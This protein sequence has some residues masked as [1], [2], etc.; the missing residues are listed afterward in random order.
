MKAFVVRIVFPFLLIAVGLYV[1]LWF[2]A[3]RSIPEQLIGTRADPATFMSS[4]ELMLAQEYSKLRNYFYFLAYPLEWFILLLLLFF[5]FG[6]RF[7]RW[8][9]SIT[10]VR[11][12][13]AGV[14]VFWLSFW[15]TLASLPLKLVRYYFSKQYQITVQPLS[16]W[17]RDQLVGFWEGLLLLWIVV[18]VIY[19]LMNKFKKYWWL[20][21]W[22]LF[23]PFIFFFM[24]V[25]PIII[26]PLYNDFYPMQNKEL[27]SKILAL[28]EEVD[29]PADRVWEVNMSEKTNAINAY[30]TGVGSNSRIVLWDTLLNRL[31]EEEILFVMAHELG[32]FVL[33]HVTLGITGYI[34]FSL[35][36]F[37]II[38][39]LCN[40]IIGRWGSALHI[41]GINQFAS[42]PL[43]L[44]L[45]SLLLFAT[46]PI[47]NYVSRHQEH[48]AD[49]FAIELT[50]NPDA[51]I[52]AFQQISKASL[53]EV[54]PPML[55]KLF[56][57]SHPPMID[58]IHFLQ[59]YH[60]ED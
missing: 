25:Q 57:Y 56:R 34:L 23:V 59:T 55:V 9:E 21:T 16:S 41:K 13:Q 28:A 12:L 26:D 27:E 19:W 54:N 52:G 30:V 18:L 4:H 40:F 10:R 37:Y 43:L 49:V 53:S 20:A 33:H 58:R 50:K 45:V 24:Y 6:E 14:F 31:H 51:A 44:L 17:V 11:V 32:H 29:V 36:A 42:L 38:Y 8:A 39:K 35:F 7:Q 60:D 2:V 5:G 48:T 46:S 47:T 15:T 22:G 3:D 1:Y